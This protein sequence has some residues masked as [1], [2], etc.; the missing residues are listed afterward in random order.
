MSEIEII[1]SLLLVVAALVALAGRLGVPYP[2]LL[3]VGGAALGFVPQLPQIS[4]DPETVFLIFIPP[5]VYSAAF[6]TSWR[7]FVANKRPILLLAVGLVFVSTIVV[8]V[9]A[10]AVVGMDWAP[11]FVL[12]AVVSNTDTMA[13][14][15]IAEHFRLPRRILTILEG[16]SLINDAAGLTAFR[17][18]VAATVSGIF[19]VQDIGGDL[20]L[21]VLGAIPIGLAVG[22]LSA[23]IRLRTTDTNIEGI[24]ALLTPY[25]A[26]LPADQLG[27]S[28]ILAVVITGLYVGRREN[29]YEDA[30]T[31]L[32]LRGV[33]NVGIFILNGLL[34]ILVGLQ[35]RSIWDDL[36]QD[37]TGLILRN[38][39][40]IGLT[41]ILVRVAWVFISAAASQWLGS[42]KMLTP[43]LTNWDGIAIISWA[44]LR[45]ADTLAAALSVPLLIAT[46]APFPF[47]AEIIFFAFAVI[48]ATLVGQGLTLPPLIRWLS[49]AGDGAEE[50]EEVQARRA[51]S[52]AAL[53]RI[54]ELAREEAVAT[55]VVDLLRRHYSHEAQLLAGGDG[56]EPSMNAA[57]QEIRLRREILEAQRVAVSRLRDQGA[58]SD[59]VMRRVQR[60][61]DLEEAR[62]VRSE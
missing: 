3:V 54:D 59:D 35:L 43:A 26:Y 14:V 62:F 45:G 46:G 32:Q 53:A 56:V 39:A 11:A 51:A 5:L 22:W 8:A 23:K 44:G 55:D 50:A 27:A 12:G 16:E 42:R 60:E 40:V 36:V 17:I 37:D 61:L 29:L 2:I 58:I 21:A 10:H 7:D 15:A 25:A 33:W 34:F 4:I 9:I 24:I 38:A 41:V 20:A 19:T 31:R 47:R 49:V 13:T 1:L 6:F 30:V 48:A 57:Q 52:G 18:A 28:G